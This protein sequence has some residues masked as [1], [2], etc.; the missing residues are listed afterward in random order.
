[1]AE[2][3]AKA[4]NKPAKV[5]TNQQYIEKLSGGKVITDEIARRTDFLTKLKHLHG[6]RNRRGA[7]K[8]MATASVHRDISIGLAGEINEHIDLIGSDP[9][10]FIRSSKKRDDQ[11]EDDVAQLGDAVSTVFK[12]T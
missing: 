3:K 10:F 9:D 6:L 4:A 5:Q 7:L 1:M 2:S 11:W 8:Q 12:F